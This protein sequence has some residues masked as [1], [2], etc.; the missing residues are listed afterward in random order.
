MDEVGLN[1]PASTPD[2]SVGFGKE[3]ENA[4]LYGN[5]FVSD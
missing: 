3:P 1:A 5:P 4:E 2:Q